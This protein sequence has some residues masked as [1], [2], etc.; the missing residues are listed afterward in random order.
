MEKLL[1]VIVIED[2]DKHRLLLSEQLCLGQIVVVAAHSVIET[3]DLLK[4]GTC[5]LLL[6]DVAVAGGA[7]LSF[8]AELKRNGIDLPDYMVAVGADD[9]ATKQASAKAGIISY[10]VED[11]FYEDAVLVIVR[12]LLLEVVNAMECRAK[13]DEMADINMLNQL[14]VESSL[15][16]IVFSDNGL[17]CILWNNFMEQLTG[18]LASEMLGQNVLEKLTF[19][20]T[21]GMANCVQEALVQGK[22]AE[23]DFEFEIEQTEKSGWVSVSVGP[24]RNADGLIIGVLTLVHDITAK[25]QI[26]L[27][28]LRSRE[29][30]YDLFENAPIGYHEIDMDGRIV[31]V[32]RTELNMLGYTVAEMQGKEVWQF[33]DDTLQSRECTQNKLQ[34]GVFQEDVYERVFLT[35][36]GEP[37]NI[38]L[39]DR[40]IYGTD[41]RVVG[42]RSSLQNITERK[43]AELQTEQLKKYF[44]TIIEKSP[45]GY[46]LLDNQGLFKYISPS[47]L[48]MFG[49]ASDEMIE[50]NP[51][52]LTHTDDLPLV[53]QHLERVM[54]DAVYVPVIQ[55]RFRRKDGTWLWIE[56]TFT[57]QLQE[58]SVEAIVINFR[59]IHERRLFQDALILNERRLE[60]L[61]KINELKFISEKELLD[62]TLA[63]IV[64]LTGSEIGFLA[65]Y[66]QAKD[67]Y[68]LLAWSR[69][70]LMDLYFDAER[71]SLQSSGIWSEAVKTKKPIIINDF[72]SQ[73]RRVSPMPS[74]HV[75]LKRFLIIPVVFED[76]VVALAAVANK[77]NDYDD[78]D[79]RQLTL[80]MS[81]LWKIISKKRADIMLN[82][83]EARFRKVFDSS[84]VGKSIT[85]MDGL[86]S[87]NEAF[88]RM[89]GYS[90]NEINGLNWRDVTHPDDIAYNDEILSKITSGEIKSFQ[91]EKRFLHREGRIVWVNITTTLMSESDNTGQF[92]VTEM[93][94]IT[95]TKEASQKIRESEERYRMLAENTKDVIWKTDLTGNF[96]YISPSVYQM[97]GYLPD[98]VMMQ[99]AADIVL[100]EYV[101]VVVSAFEGALTK[102][103]GG[104]LVQYLEVEQRCKNGTSVWTESSAVVLRNENK[105]PI[106]FVGV[107]RDISER[108]KAEEALK[109][110]RDVL[111]RLYHNSSQFIE[112]DVESVD[113]QMIADE[114]RTI[115][116]ARFG[117]FNLFEET[118]GD[119]R[120]MAVSG[121][122]SVVKSIKNVLGYEPLNKKWT[123][124]PEREKLIAGRVFTK[125][126]TLSELTRTFVSPSVVNL[127]TRMFGLGEVWIIQVQK[128]GVPVGDF[129]LLFEKDKTLLNT[130]ILELYV[131]QIGL[132]IERI[133]SVNALKKSEEVYRNL[134]MKI[135]DGVYKSTHYGKFLEVNPALVQ[136]L[137]YNNKEELMQINILSELYFKVSDRDDKSFF[138]SRADDTRSVFP[139]RKKDG[140]PVWVE[141][142]GWYN[143]DE[144]GKVV[145]HEGVLRDVTQRL[146]DEEFLKE[147]EKKFRLLFEQNPQPMLIYDM[148][149]Y[150]IM[151]VNESAVN[152]YGYTREE[153]LE[154]TIA[155]LRTKEE[156]PHF[157]DF[158]YHLKSDNP[159]KYVQ[160]KHVLKNGDVRDVEV[161]SATIEV[162]GKKARQVLI[163]DVTERLRVESALRMSESNLSEALKLAGMAFWEYDLASG[164]FTFN[165]QF[166]DIYNTNAGLAGGYRMLAQDYADRYMFPDDK[167]LVADLIAEAM[168]SVDEDFFKKLDHR[169][170]CG[171][172]L[173]KYI[174]VSVKVETS[175]HGVAR[176]LI[177]ANQDI[178]SRK[179][180]ELLLEKSE[181]FFRNSQKAAHIGSYVL[182][183]EK[184]VWESSEVLDELLGIDSDYERVMIRWSNLVH[185]DERRQMEDY[186][187]KEV[188][189]MKKHFNKEYRIRRISDGGVRWVHG[190]GELLIENGKIL[191]MTGTIQDITDRKEAE[192]QLQ[193]RV[194]ELTR[195]QNVTIDRELAMI[196][197][198]KEVNAL[199]EQSGQLKKY[200]IFE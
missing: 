15:G 87:V 34:N 106:G 134:V 114:I 135:P 79:T 178:T 45:D 12:K 133:R 177:G 71:I 16:G 62:A 96:T 30:F 138:T 92:L 162:N 127:I 132:F 137:G 179:L 44:Q 190:L 197:L 10:V 57:N 122:N 86:L 176:K 2:T 82:E 33:L 61:L 195:F 102:S 25:K 7:G 39:A 198:K 193:M 83:S 145:S 56:S 105:E 93:Y 8:L 27:A 54:A 157:L 124:D 70:H 110:N 65:S 107:T 168:A 165:D 66:E 131:A 153:F 40:A 164:V 18:L 166:Y 98:E 161:F 29:E 52:N 189:M 20:R 136:M 146:K 160:T 119:F 59:D 196:E 159:Q 109:Q 17:K 46:V 88:A 68:E 182:D 76:S 95:A 200:K 158:I 6:L 118:G 9:K 63:E 28:L 100:P 144:S 85:T 55:Y 1:K 35:K 154:L 97:R 38:L 99:T 150:G 126:N 163:N 173:V 167:H 21:N 51:H 187:E 53:L 194:D 152:H 69:E 42:L 5:A 183:V 36:S 90:N 84:N 191:K 121:W 41:G 170:V 32:N 116:G 78:S 151:D 37:L 130:D 199:L 4:D 75:A 81:S 142:H 172:G 113:Y 111:K 48:R 26:E 3:I 22:S 148:D 104:D 73:M 139:L 67:K 180:T 72:G 174:S 140:T 175:R 128:T 155:D 74:G 23:L 14:V 103:E 156:Y 147:N 171:D 77:M 125:F 58:P 64:S 141:D 108:K 115:G 80:M 43:K 181:L 185:E 19:L 112:M 89:L 149:K 24:M 47:A 11:E 13:L 186:F 129:T 94:D 31:R 143:V 169:I 192:V 91:W 117:V 123:Y 50:E 184:G 188:L 49:Y 60:S 101:D 120:T